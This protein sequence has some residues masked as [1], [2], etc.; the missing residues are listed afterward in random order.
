MTEKKTLH[1]PQFQ[2]VQG[3]QPPEAITPP[4]E[5]GAPQETKTS[6][7]QKDS[8][9]SSPEASPPISKPK[10]NPPLT[11]KRLGLNKD[12]HNL[13]LTKYQEK[14]IQELYLQGGKQLLLE[15]IQKILGQ[16]ADTST[17]SPVPETTPA[18][19]A[20]VLPQQS[21][22][23]LPP[24]DKNDKKNS[25]LQAFVIMALLVSFL[26][27]V[28]CMVVSAAS[29]RKKEEESINSLTTKSEQLMPA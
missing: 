2:Q 14:E 21:S 1:P 10:H 29:K 25:G 5:E 3:S 9:A 7:T 12:Q 15:T 6:L 11:Y 20:E 18:V 4:Q 28:I 22:D 26:G 23:S 8:S 19:V 24:S 16:E 17:T 27:L 13:L